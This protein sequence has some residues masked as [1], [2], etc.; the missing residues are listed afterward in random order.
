M[1]TND[2]LRLYPPSLT[3]TRKAAKEV[4]L[5]LILLPPKLNIIILILAIHHHSR[6]IW[7]D[8]AFIFKQDRFVRGVAN[9]TTHK[10]VSFLPFGL[11]PRTC[12]GSNLTTNEAKIVFSMILKKYKYALSTNYVN[13]IRL[14]RLFLNREME[15]K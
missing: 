13:D 6:Q 2:Y 12:E 4:K 9:A 7:G 3:L 11:G 10:S 1:I 14:M 5:G 15:F 8:D